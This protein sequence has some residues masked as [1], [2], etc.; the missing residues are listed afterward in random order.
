MSRL[1]T[2]TIRALRGIRSELEVKLDGKSMSLQGDNGTGKSSIVHG[3]RWVL[4][5]VNP[6]AA[7]A[8][9]DSEEGL[10]R[11]ILET[12]PE[13]PRVVIDL[14]PRGRIEITPERCIADAD[15]EAF[16]RACMRAN[17]FLRRPD[18][19]GFLT[20]KPGERFK[21]LET[22]L[23]LDTADALREAIVGRAK[24][25][26]DV[27]KNSQHTLETDL[28]KAASLLP[29]VDRKPATWGHVLRSFIAWGQRLGIAIS[30]DSSW[31]ELEMTA[32]SVGDTLAGESI[33]KNRA[34][35]VDCDESLRMLQLPPDGAL[36]LAQVI[37]QETRLSYAELAA[38]LDGAMGYFENVVDADNCPVCEQSVSRG[39]LMVRLAARRSELNE[40]EVVRRR[41]R[42]IGDEWGRWADRIVEI[43]LECQSK[44]ASA[45]PAQ[46]IA[47]SSLPAGRE[48][49]EV[50]V[51]RHGSAYRDIAAADVQALS[52]AIG[53]ALSSLPTEAQVEARRAFVAAVAH[54]LGYQLAVEL[55]LSQCEKYKS[56]A[57]LLRHAADALKKARH[58]VAQSL[59]NEIGQLVA[60]FYTEIHPPDAADEVTGPPTIEVQ[61][62]GGGTAF[63]R[64][65][66]ENRK[67]ED[68][69][70]VYSDGHLDTVGICVF[71]ALRRFRANRDKAQDPKLMVLDDVVLSI[72]L[73]HARRLL[74]VLRDSFADHQVLV[75]THNG[76]F[77]EWCSK[78]LP[79]YTRLQIV[80]WSLE[81]GPSLG[82]HTTSLDRLRRAHLEESVPKLL[83]QAM[84]NF[85]DEWM[86]DARFAY[87]LRLP[88]RHEYTLA[89]LW[90]PF[91][92]HFLEVTKKFP[93]GPLRQAL[94]RLPDI[95]TM[96]NKL[97]AH[98]ND[99]AREYPLVTLRAV[100]TDV[101]S[102]VDSLYCGKCAQ[103][104]VP[105]PQMGIPD[106]HQCKCKNLRHV[107]PEKGAMGPS[108]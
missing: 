75:M 12:D 94:E 24:A 86:L 105:I 81:S 55:S 107:R 69:Q 92:S 11:H 20:A 8:S 25:A 89:D 74:A 79:S 26:D 18:L 99:F 104:A 43:R 47:A 23:D 17:P 27:L 76:L 40:I 60:S 57:Q 100:A 53:A 68:P 65:L 37:A 15:G 101:L 106:L 39:E 83:A 51:S 19:L 48:A 64:G 85:L 96:R 45:M 13:A 56:T 84:M 87:G 95:M 62:H 108:S 70:W 78:Y 1:G 58:V 29:V 7:Q 98:E 73:G 54:A 72:D 10:R 97:A 77:M 22:F 88:S 67:V 52:D 80:R 33:A 36:L 41:L 21:Y 50:L 9:F 42:G 91:R 46:S 16:Q 2:I 14:V 82:S 5:G 103:F 34:A 35:L 66:F 31:A 71:L 90:D 4:L 28:A 63:V 30:T 93:L 3:L 49:I 44:L 61:G 32:I 38:L 6:P 102:V 59:L